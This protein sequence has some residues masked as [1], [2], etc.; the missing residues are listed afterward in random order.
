[1][2]A[3]PNCL[4]YFPLLWLPMGKATRLHLW[5][6]SWFKQPNWDLEA[7]NSTGLQRDIQDWNSCLHSLPGIWKCVN[8]PC[9]IQPEWW[10]LTSNFC[11]F[12]ILFLHLF[13]K[14]IFQKGLNRLPG[15]SSGSKVHCCVLKKKRGGGIHLSYG[16]NILLGT[17]NFLVSW[18]EAHN[19][20]VPSVR[21]T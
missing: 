19:H 5:H 9:N 7:L 2:Q 18:A 8:Y 12:T 3:C 10:W 15:I 16:R 20:S 1:M 11:L 14:M 21:A 17:G 4:K 13:L 6:L